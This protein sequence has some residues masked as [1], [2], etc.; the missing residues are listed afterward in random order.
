MATLH[1][2]DQDPEPTTLQQVLTF[3]Q[4]SFPLTAIYR[5][6]VVA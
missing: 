6:H 5:R 1:H 2:K 4:L 3:A